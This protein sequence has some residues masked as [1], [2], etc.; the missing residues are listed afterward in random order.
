MSYETKG[1]LKFWEEDR[2]S[3][4]CVPNSGSCC[5]IDY[6]MQAD[7]LGELLEKINCFTSNSDEDAILLDACEEEGRV[8][9]QVLETE[10][11]YP[12]SPAQL[13][14]WKEGKLKLWLCDYSF[15]IEK[16]SREKVS[17]LSHMMEQ[18]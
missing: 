6:P 10:E 2:Y 16:V 4:G 14:A 11:S 5:W 17:L 7:T 8:D 18:A 13:Q 1:C 3:E 9:I 15:Q 12:P